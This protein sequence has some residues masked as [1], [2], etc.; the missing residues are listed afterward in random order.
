MKEKSRS[1][2]KHQKI[3]I[4]K[5]DLPDE[6]VVDLQSFNGIADIY[7]TLPK[8]NGNMLEAVK[9]LIDHA[10]ENTL[11]LYI[12]AFIINYPEIVDKIV[13]VAETLRGKIYVLTKLEKNQI[14]SIDP[15]VQS[16][17]D[18]SSHTSM[19]ERMVKAGIRVRSSNAHA[20]FFLVGKSRAIV[21]SANITP[22]SY[23][24]NP[25]LGVLLDSHH[26]SKLREW[27]IH[28]WKYHTDAEMRRNPHKLNKRKCDDDHQKFGKKKVLLNA[29]GDDYKDYLLHMIESAQKKLDIIT[30]SLT[31]KEVIDAIDERAREGVEVRIVLPQSMRRIWWKYNKMKK[32]EDHTEIRYYREIHAKLMIVDKKKA[33][34]T[35]GNLDYYM[36]DSTFDVGVALRQTDELN[37]FFDGIFEMALPNLQVDHDYITVDHLDLKLLIHMLHRINPLDKPLSLSQFESILEDSDPRFYYLDNKMVIMYKEGKG[38]R[39][40]WME[41]TEDG[42]RFIRREADSHDRIKNEE[43]I[44]YEKINLEAYTVE[45]E[46][47]EDEVKESQVDRSG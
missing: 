46:E 27:F 22:H 40:M 32:L 7:Y 34:V 18:I 21:G 14:Y 26:A 31:D 2:I 1:Y 13:D 30:Y 11:P 42:W 47:K 38:N 25:E 43:A 39:Y 8:K 16:P 10:V 29:L 44:K 28:V 33:A 20:K 19:I 23:D 17:D 9:N 37:Q 35:T 12:S 45:L 4:N 24:S 41:K 5:S 36:R 6:R 15:D 3:I